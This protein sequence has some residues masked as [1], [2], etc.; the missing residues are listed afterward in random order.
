[1]VDRFSAKRVKPAVPAEAYDFNGRVKLVRTGT[2]RR[3][4]EFVVHGAIFLPLDTAGTEWVQ[5]FDG[6]E[7]SIQVSSGPWREVA[8]ASGV[9]GG[10]LHP[11]IVLESAH[12]RH[13]DKKADLPALLWTYRVPQSV[14]A[15]WPLSDIEVLIDLIPPEGGARKTAAHLHI[16][17]T[18]D[19]VWSKQTGVESSI[20]RVDE[21]V[22][23][24]SE[25]GGASAYEV[26]RSRPG[27][28]LKTIDQYLDSL[29]GP[30]D[31]LQTPVAT[32]F[33]FI[34]KLTLEA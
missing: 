18:E 4:V 29:R 2:W 10:E 1:M 33:S 14:T 8:M 3:G 15:T 22:F 17:L 20:G 12:Y 19:A 34:F 13:I 9:C 25:V 24:V 31:P 16:P 28:E 26:W 32:D 7:L 5:T 6:Y 30:D 11:H 23:L 21:S 27:N